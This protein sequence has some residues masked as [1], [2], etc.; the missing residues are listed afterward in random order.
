MGVAE[1]DAWREANEEAKKE[2]L[3]DGAKFAFSH[4]ASALEKREGAARAY[5]GWMTRYAKQMK[6]HHVPFE[7]LQGKIETAMRGYMNAKLQVVG[8]TVLSKGMEAEEIFE[9][10]RT[11]AGLVA[12]EATPADAAMNAALNDPTFQKFVRS[13]ATNW[14][15]LRSKLDV[16]SS[17]GEL[18]RLSPHYALASLLVDGSYDATKWTASRNRLMQQYH[19][20][21]AELTAVTSLQHQIVR[22]LTKLKQCRGE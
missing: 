4:V 6:Q 8:G 5:K 22:T 19:L 20:S 10:F 1:I 3:A 7:A 12:R 9:N 2:A 17:A 16:F 18:K 14:D 11:Q 13:D 21:D 15:F